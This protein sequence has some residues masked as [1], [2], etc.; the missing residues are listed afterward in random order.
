[1]KKALLLFACTLMAAAQL[2]AQPSAVRSTYK[3]S[4]AQSGRSIQNVRIDMKAQKAAQLA[5]MQTATMAED[6]APRAT[7]V[8]SRT[9]W[10]AAADGVWFSRP[11]GTLVT[12][13]DD[14]GMGYYVNS[15]ITPPY[16]NLVFNNQSTD[17]A[18]TSWELVSSSGVT[19]MNE[20]ADENNDL[21]FGS[22]GF[23]EPAFDPEERVWYTPSYYQPQLTDGTVTYRFGEVNNS[24]YT[25]TRRSYLRCDTIGM[26]AYLDERTCSTNYGWGSLVSNFSNNYLLGSGTVTFKSGE[27]AT[28]MGVVQ[29]FP[30]PASPLYVE[31]ISIDCY[32]STQP[33]KNGAELTMRIYNVVEDEEGNKQPGDELIA[34]L[35]ATADDATQWWNDQTSYTTSGNVF[36]YNIAF[37]K[38]V[39]DEIGNVYDEPFSLG[40]PFAIVVSGCENPDVDVNFTA[41]IEATEDTAQPGVES[42]LND[43][44]VTWHQSIYGG[45]PMS[46]PFRFYGLFDYIEAEEVLED[47]NGEIYPNLN[48]LRVSNDGKTISTEGADE[49]HNF[50]AAPLSINFP[51]YDFEG[52][53]NYYTEED[54]PEWV[55]SY[56]VVENKTDE[57]ERTGLA[58]VTFE[59]AP[60]PADV[61]GRK[62]E[63]YFV[64]KGYK[65]AK[66]IVLLQGDATYNPG[67]YEEPPFTFA[68]ADGKYLL[69][70]VESNKSWGAGNDW[71]TRASL[72]DHP[73]YVT[74]LQQPDGTYFME[75]QVSNGGNAIYFNGDYM[76][77]GSP[78][79]LTINAAQILGFN[80]DAETQPVYGYT[81]ANGENYFG[82]DGTSTVL[83]KN[84]P[85][86]SENA[87][88]LVVSEQE[89]MAALANASAEEPADVTFLIKNPNFGRNNR[90]ADAWTVSEDCTNKNLSGGDDTNRCAESF[91]SVFTISQLLENVPNGIYALQAQ[92]FYR[93]DGEDNDNLPVFFANDQTEVFPLKTGAENSMNEA[94][95]SF[96][97][98]LYYSEP[99]Y[100]EVKDGKLN[101][102]AKLEVNTN[103]WC[104]FDNFSLKYYGADA[105]LNE[106][107]NAAIIAQL[108][109]L[110]EKA[111]SLQDQ[112]E[113]EAVKTALANAIK[114][115][116]GVSA[117]STEEEIKAAIAA[118]NE[119]VGAAEA[120]AI[121]KNVLP[122]MKNLV[123]ATNVYTEEA[124]NTYYT[125]WNEKYQAGTL[126]KG[127]ASA[128]QNPDVVTGWHAAITVDDFLL[129]AWDTNPNFN[130]A[131]YYINTWS[132][133]GDTDGSNFR[134]PFFE[135]WTGDDASLGARTLTATMSGL[136]A[137]E[138][139]V[140]ALVRVRT[141]N[142]TGSYT[143]GEGITLQVNEGE[144]VDVT[145]GDKK[146]ELAADN[147]FFVGE[148]KAK[149]NVE[150]DLN[151]K[152]NVAAENNVSW[153]SFK[154]VWYT[155][156]GVIN[157]INSLNNEAQSNTIYNLNGQKVEKAQKGLYI[158][159]GKKVV[160][161]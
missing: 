124:L 77:N 79:A 15:I 71:G 52:M 160:V 126:T 53:D 133:E 109:E 34:E 153:L 68:G 129:S 119:A 50:G 21:Q 139:E 140:K 27:V 149:G 157:G 151:I 45:D 96:K 148:F 108:Q 110:I 35:K 42:L 43:G 49:D 111:E 57:G 81:I 22:L 64:G 39:V 82:Y 131:P 143:S 25:G 135:Y 152:F 3:K 123:D 73:E 87:L 89:A 11:K 40:Q 23:Y 144:P 155:R 54:L 33:M 80:D 66:P 38:S 36:G 99:V 161:K 147:N 86:D 97:N 85:A 58:Y 118:L 112:V 137:G 141:K 95:V 100:V 117:T 16:Y 116:E 101:I 113:V 159:N 62:A 46:M 8:Q 69:V 158:M 51:W 31:H 60:L 146:Y 142:N 122:A 92:G 17:K 63:I 134:V 14:E 93:Q 127:E 145:K 72:V 56:E 12:T 4:V 13:T 55:L 37:H 115:A 67:G 7:K 59:C 84:L 114:A 90:N 121:A 1:M 26:Y 78:V 10:R 44:E 156:L 83:G 105:D 154:N 125:Q 24:Y 65:S 88:W 104:I 120:S 106:V 61:T 76:D 41:S 18:S 138:Y 128:L 2:Q 74:L 29:Y 48:V 70:N 102:G 9:P 103:L 6:L 32:T 132:V 91:H 94:S 107:K 5:N 19:D 75:S 98:G 136:E 20:Y 30:A 150:G 28:S 47:K 130:N